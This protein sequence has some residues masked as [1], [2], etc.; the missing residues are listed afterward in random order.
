MGGQLPLTRLGEVS[1]FG[2][3]HASSASSE[4]RIKADLEYRVPPVRALAA[5][6]WRL[7]LMAEGTWVSRGWL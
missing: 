1:T 2:S 5:E 6:L 3:T 4:Q 7:L